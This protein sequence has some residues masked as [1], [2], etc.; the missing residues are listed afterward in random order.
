MGSYGMVL[1][2][3]SLADWWVSYKR[4]QVAAAAEAFGQLAELPNRPFWETLLLHPP[5]GP[6]A[7][8]PSGAGF[9]WWQ[10]LTAPFVIPPGGFGV[11]ALCFLGFAFFAAGVERFLGARRF[12]ILWLVASLGAGLGG[13]LFGPLL[14]PGGVN[15][16]PGPAVLALIV[17]YC[18]MTP[19]AI[20]SV[21]MILPVKLKW[22]AALV[23]GWVL[24][25]ALAMT[26]P[27][28]AGTASG[29]YQ[30]GG[31]LAGFLWFRYGDY[32]FEGRRRRKRAGA[33]L[34]MV[35]DDAG[36]DMADEDANDDEQTYH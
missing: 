19:N 17:V 32:L 30:L 25:K 18:L 13:F 35:L 3:L 6:A 27:L 28:G 33:L 15:F 11:L 31:V 7:M 21:F 5:Q 12:L 26:S 22:I 29:G 1:L 36:V 2:V 8:D 16:G 34:K 4:Q 20:V 23:A 10:V 14:Q 9:Q 24:V